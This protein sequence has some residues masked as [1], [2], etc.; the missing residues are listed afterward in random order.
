[1]HYCIVPGSFVINY[2]FC[3]D[4]LT[5]C[6]LFT[7]AMDQFFNNISIKSILFYYGCLG[8]E[9][10]EN[11]AHNWVCKPYAVTRD[12]WDGMGCTDHTP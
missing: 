4:F 2:L 12:G 7:I 5:F 9:E 6:S 10:L 3:F 8:H 11:I 1:M